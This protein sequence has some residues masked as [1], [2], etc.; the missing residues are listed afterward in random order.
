MAIQIR[1]SAKGNHLVFSEATFKDGI[2]DGEMKLGVL[3]I[4]DSSKAEAILKKAKSLK[5]EMGDDE[6]D[7]GFYPVTRVD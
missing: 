7:S 6:D 3:Q 4:E 2:Q 5:W 1:L